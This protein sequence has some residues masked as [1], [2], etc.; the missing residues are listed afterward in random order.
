MRFGGV[1]DN[2]ERGGFAR[3]GETLDALNS[4]RRTEHILNYGHLGAVEMR[5][6][7]GKSDGLFARQNRLNLALPFADTA[8]DF[9]L[10][11]DGLG[12]GEL[13]RR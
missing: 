12:G 10:C 5:M 8:D 4:V 3:A 7:V 11:F 6:L 1:A 9:M 13:A 2:R